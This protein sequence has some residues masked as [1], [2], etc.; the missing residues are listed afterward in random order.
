MSI[1]DTIF[2]TFAARGGLE[3]GERVSIL[4]HSLQTATFAEQDGLPDHLIAAAL[5][6]DYGH[7]IHDLPEDIADHGI[8]G[9]HEE[10][11]ATWLADYFSPEVVEPIRL[12]VPAKRYLCATDAEYYATL[13]LASIQ[14]LNVQGGPF[15]AD[16]V[17]TFEA[18]HHFQDAITLRRYD[19]L[20]KEVGMATPQVSHFRPYLERY[21][22]TL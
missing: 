17:K 19:E 1:I 10:V 20:G 18:N 7:L 22:Q 2:Q 21:L 11:G 4:E 15:T 12:H 6:H 3:Y 9:Q 8:D 16:E 13:S 5:L 14:S